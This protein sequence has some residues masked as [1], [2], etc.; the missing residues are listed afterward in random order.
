MVT[1]LTDS[2]RP[3]RYVG[4]LVCRSSVSK[5]SGVSAF[6]MLFGWGAWGQDTPGQ[7]M[8]SEALAIIMK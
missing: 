4:S 7:Q 8:A 2:L 3:D 5:Q 1:L 6:D